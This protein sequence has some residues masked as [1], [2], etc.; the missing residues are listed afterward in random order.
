MHLLL[1]ADGAVGRF[2]C[3]RDTDDIANCS[4]GFPLFFL[5]PW[6]RSL[7]RRVKEEA[8]EPLRM[9]VRD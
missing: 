8:E 5:S 9:M 2:G 3:A 6:N 4:M 7:V 1:V